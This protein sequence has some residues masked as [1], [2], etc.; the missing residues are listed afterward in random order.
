MI[1]VINNVNNV[2]INFIKMMII[3]VNYHLIIS[4]FIVNHGTFKYKEIFN[5]QYVIIVKILHFQ[6][7]IIKNIFVLKN[8][9]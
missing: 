3:N 4:H 1:M 7:N 6:Y 8:L 9:I 5:H 2:E